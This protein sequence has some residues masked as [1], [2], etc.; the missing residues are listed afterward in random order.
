MRQVICRICQLETPPAD[1]SD[2]D[3]LGDLGMDSLIALELRGELG[4]SLRLEGKISPTVAFE[5]GTIGELTQRLMTIAMEQN[6]SG[7]GKRLERDTKR[8]S[9]EI[10]VE[11]L[12][13]MTDAQVEE[14]L[15]E[16][17]S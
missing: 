17:I 7:N 13:A 10:K 15:K 4:K 8:D 2:R 12:E 6:K 1:L 14:L 16:R 5:T 3:R 9:L 11:A